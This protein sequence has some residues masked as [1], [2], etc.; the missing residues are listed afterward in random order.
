MAAALETDQPTINIGEF[1]LSNL[2]ISTAPVINKNTRNIGNYSDP[3]F[4][5]VSKKLPTKWSAVKYSSP[6]GQIPVMVQTPWLISN[7]IEKHEQTAIAY[8]LGL[9]GVIKDTMTLRFPNDRTDEQE[10]F[11]T[12]LEE[13]DN[14]AIDLGKKNSWE[15]L[16][17]S[18]ADVE[19]KYKRSYK[20][21]DGRMAT[22]SFQITPPNETGH[23]IAFFTKENN[24]IA[25]DKVETYFSP[26]SKAR[27][28]I[29]CVGIAYG[30]DMF[31]LRWRVHQTMIDRYELVGSE[32]KYKK[33]ML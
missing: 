11:A 28:V 17:C 3:D 22:I 29:Q 32:I 31:V 10:Q 7:G 30:E 20:E 15:W 12:F 25:S 5:T 1:N 4:Q 33:C 19:A 16:N 14:W 23:N 18:A 27:C 2:V 13:L 21:H 8:E 24:P 9:R 26:K 6:D